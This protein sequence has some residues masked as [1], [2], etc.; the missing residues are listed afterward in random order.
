MSKT[1]IWL[2]THG[3]VTGRKR[4]AECSEDLSGRTLSKIVVDHAHDKVV[5]KKTSTSCFKYYNDG[6]FVGTRGWTRW[7]WDF[8]G[9][10]HGAT[11]LL[12][13]RSGC[14]RTARRLSQMGLVDDEWSSSCPF[15]LAG[16][17]ETLH[18]FFFS[19]PFFDDLRKE[20]L[21][22][23]DELASHGGRSTTAKEKLTLLLGG[24]VRGSPLFDWEVSSSQSE[25]DKP[26]PGKCVQ[27]IQYLDACRVVR[28]PVLCTKS[29]RSSS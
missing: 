6:D 12:Q 13:C 18:H 19:C 24:A 2:K 28:A 15:C 23:L 26:T 22:F 11:M 21:N 7:L 25:N 17:P 27:I 5:S 8:P 29:R 20:H 14:F 16:E 4:L 10:G 1:A 9:L 3:P